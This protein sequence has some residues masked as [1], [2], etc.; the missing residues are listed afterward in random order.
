MKLLFTV[1]LLITAGLGFTIFLSYSIFLANH[2]ILTESVSPEFFE[3]LGLSIVGF[4][5]G[6]G[7][8][9]SIKE[10]NKD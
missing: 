3:S 6:I 10:L 4:V 7:S 2:M 1:F 9:L 8:L 5:F